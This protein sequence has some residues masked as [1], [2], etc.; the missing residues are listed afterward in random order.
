M[1]IITLHYLQYFLT[2]KVLLHLMVQRCISDFHCNLESC[3]CCSDNDGYHKTHPCRMFSSRSV[4][5]VGN[6]NELIENK[7]VQP[8]GMYSKQ[9]RISDIMAHERT[10]KFRDE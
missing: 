6:D 5:G 3:V 10:I 7:F 4:Y 1:A 8:N 9:T 2:H